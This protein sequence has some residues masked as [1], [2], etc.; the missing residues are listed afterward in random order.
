MRYPCPAPLR[1]VGLSLTAALLLATGHAAAQTAVDS[2]EAQ[3]ASVPATKP[4]V[5]TATTSLPAPAAPERK[6]AAQVTLSADGQT[7][8]VVGMILEGSFHRFDTV[9]RSAPKARTVYLSSA[10]GYTIEARLIAALVR[11]YKLDTYV[12]FYCASACTQIFASGRQRTIG[13]NGQLGFHQAILLNER[14]VPTRT[15]PRTE[16]KL[17]STTVFG[18]NGNDTLRLAYELAGF[19]TAFIDK[20]LSYSHDNMWVPTPD[21]LLA[22]HVITSRSERADL[23]TVPGG[24]SSR[25]EVRSRLLQQP[26]WRT[27]LA[28]RP[29]R[30]EKA[31]DTV[32]RNANIGM[33]YDE[34]VTTGR[35][36]IVAEA[37]RTLGRAP[38]ALL[39]RSLALYGGFA[40][41]QRE[42][43]YPACRNEI[44]VAPERNAEDV[45]FEQSEDTL[46][47]DFLLSTELQEPM[48]GTDA[49][50][51]FGREVVP[52][53]TAS[54]TVNLRL[55]QEGKCRLG[56]QTFEAI[57]TLP[58]KQRVRAYR[59]LLSLPGLAGLE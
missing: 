2:R 29:D 12:G 53:L 50:R 51:I 13:P 57:D 26:L 38:D 44:G 16:R 25:D 48:N 52:K 54:Y 10:G 23:S 11:K 49:S 8:Y 3:R 1:H 6:T 42:R 47:A 58:P 34:A 41:S 43:G 55:G 20:A 32:W 28:K 22:A 5:P 30:T 24:I 7:I 37:T 4:H 40:R 39:E 45:A 21:E 27:A 46:I 59:A 36:G 14:G 15:R 31:I 17:T 9:L 18:V 35:A 19:D 56:Y 33:S